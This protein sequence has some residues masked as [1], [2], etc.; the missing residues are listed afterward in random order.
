[1]HFTDNQYD[2]VKTQVK[3]EGLIP[4]HLE[5]QNLKRI[6][7]TIFCIITFKQPI[8]Q[9][10]EFGHKHTYQNILV[11][12]FAVSGNDQWRLLVFN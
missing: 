3:V 1:M 11:K 2:D 10:Y 5:L 12:Y 7:L 4:E 9:L 8:H 6:F